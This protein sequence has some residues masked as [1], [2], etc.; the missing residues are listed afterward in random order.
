MDT[1]LVFPMFAMVLLSGLTV[2]GLFFSRLSAVSS[3]ST[4]ITYYKTYNGPS[5]EDRRSQQLSR[6]VTNQ[7][8]APVLF[9]AACLA[10]LVVQKTGV[11]FLC[12]AWAYVGLRILHTLIHITSNKI[13]LRLGSYMA[14][15]FVLLAMWISLA[16]IC[17]SA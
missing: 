6:N 7:F 10:A 16:W 14:S 9:Y 17:F 4:P 13:P 12:L 15:W 8:E 5:Q 11:V 1:D 3:G 2:F